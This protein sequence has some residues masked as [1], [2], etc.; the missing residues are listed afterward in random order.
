VVDFLDG[1]PDRP[2]ITGS[3]HHA[4]NVP[5]YPLPTDKTKSTL[6]TQTYPGGNGSNELRFED[7]KGS[8][9]VYLHAQKE[10]KIQVEHD[11][12]QHVGQHEDLP[13][14]RDRPVTVPGAHTETIGLAQA[15]T[16]GAAQIT[17]VGAFMSVNVGLAKT[18]IVGAS[19]RETVGINKFSKA[20][21]D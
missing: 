16:V 3:V 18:E 13:V 6:K 17:S 19:S 9:E 7:K 21:V 14:G 15:I 12:H 10:L 8:E 1:N 20:G 2:I 4:A 5:P 11:K